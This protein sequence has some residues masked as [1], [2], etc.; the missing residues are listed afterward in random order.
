MS[1]IDFTEI[2]DPTRFE[3]FAKHYL[4][5]DGWTI[6]EGPGMG[7]DGSKD[8]IA[9]ITQT[10]GFQVRMLV[11]CKN[12]RRAVGTDSSELS[13]LDQHRCSGFLYFYSSYPTEGL[14]QQ[15][16]QSCAPRRIPYNIITGADIVRGLIED[17]RKRPLIYHFFPAS[18]ARMSP[19]LSFEWCPNCKE[20]TMGDVFAYPVT[21]N[22]SSPGWMVACGNCATYNM[23][24]E[25]AHSRDPIILIEDPNKDYL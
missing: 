17:P 1:H 25:I 5:C 22:D 6:S 14:R 8:F 11:S 10:Y 4:A 2:T 19:E 18:H 7:P 13:R 12:H 24:D 23:P 15:I 9:T 20:H 16:D 21:N 3:E